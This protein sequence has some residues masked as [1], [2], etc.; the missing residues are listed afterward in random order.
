MKD[1]KVYVYNSISC[2]WESE[3]PIRFTDL[4][5]E[6]KIDTKE[7]ISLTREQIMKN[8]GGVMWKEEV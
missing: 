8:I 7:I 6:E 5:N 3:S 4:E 1:K 2:L